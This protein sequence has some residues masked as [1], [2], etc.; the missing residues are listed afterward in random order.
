MKNKILLLFCALFFL[1]IGCYAQNRITGVVVDEQGE[2]VIGATVRVKGDSSTGSITNVE[3][4]F[5]ISTSPKSVLIISFVGMKTQEVK[6]STSPIKIVLQSASE[7]LDEVVVTG[8]QKMDKRLFTGATSKLSADNV[9]MDGIPDISRAL[10]GRAA[11]VSVQNVSGTFGTAPKIRVR[12]AT[13]IYGSSKPLWVVDGVIMDGVADVGADDLSSGDALT[14]ISSAISGL[15]ADDI[16]SFQIL[17][18]GS[19]TSIYGAKAMAGVIVIT[20]KKGKS[21]SNKISYTGEFSMRLRPNYRD[22]NIMNSQE[23]MSVLRELD[24]NGLLGFANV[25]RASDSGVYGK[26]YHLINNY[27][28]KTGFG[29]PNTDEAR[30][31]YL[32]QAEYRNTDWFKL[33]F[34]NSISQNHAISFSTGTDKAS[35]YTSLSIMNDPGWTIQNKVQRYTGN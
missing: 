4:K 25:F 23:Q 26:M 9:K 30:I 6:A 10:E 17:K 34:N 32:Q 11:G 8:M 3:G 31:P 22:Y 16:E 15:N 14:L 20:T 2:A 24:N 5:T 27:S 12:G 21:G 35:Y 13:S 19:A 7:V 29:L 1:G 18:D 28:P 33:L